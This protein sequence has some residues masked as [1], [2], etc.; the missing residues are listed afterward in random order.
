MRRL[1]T[2]AVLAAS[3]VS[4]GG[5]GTNLAAD[6]CSKVAETMRSEATEASDL[7][8]A[9]VT[10]RSED[11]ALANAGRMLETAVFAGDFPN[12]KRTA[13]LELI[14]DRCKELRPS[15]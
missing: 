3:V 4:C 5:G 15:E 9:D 13:A 8:M 14:W 1:V 11:Q 10:Q 12:T 7:A 6:A 2:L